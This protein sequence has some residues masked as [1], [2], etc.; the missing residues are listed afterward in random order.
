MKKFICIAV[1]LWGYCA[2]GG[3]FHLFTDLKGRSVGAKIIKVD[4]QRGL[5][6]LELEN[7]RRSKVKPSVFI[8]ED[9]DYIRDWAL[10]NAFMSSSGLRFKA[11]KEVVEDW[12][13][14]GGVGVNRDFEKVVYNCEL[15]NGS[16]HTYENLEMDYCVYWV[17]EVAENNGERRDEKYKSGTIDLRS[18]QPRQ[19]NDVQTEPVVLLYQHL[20]GG[21]Y[22]VDGAPGK[23]SSKMKGVW[24]RIKLT[25]KSG[26]EYVREFCEPASV[27]KQQVWH[28][29]K[30]ETN[31]KKKKK[32]RQ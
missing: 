4:P 25:T 30:K 32:G 8:K 5:V 27:M 19:T 1:L 18:L 2:F 16:L 31:S 26:T 11:E 28:E 12:Y 29:P 6:E 15:K 10:G 22:Y 9:Q 20:A 21:Y 23:Q 17:Q 14:S 3:E 13:E 24:V 7:K